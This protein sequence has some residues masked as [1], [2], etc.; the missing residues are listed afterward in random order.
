MGQ[1]VNPYDYSM[2]G[3]ATQCIKDQIFGVAVGVFAI[4]IAAAVPTNLLLSK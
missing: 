4:G 2:Y 1:R 3:I